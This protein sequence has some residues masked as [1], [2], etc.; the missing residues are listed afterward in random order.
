M[1]ARYEDY[2]YES[3]LATC[4]HAYLMPLIR[5]ML[6]GCGGPILDIGCGNGAIARA[7]LADGFDVHGIDASATGVEIASAAAPGR[8]FV[9][10][11]DARDLPPQL[12]GTAFAAVMST[13]VIEHLYAP[14]ALLALA[15]RV[16][17]PGGDLVLSTPYHGYL[18]NLA[19]AASGRLDRHFTVLWDGGHIKF[20]S[21]ATLGRMLREEGFEVTRFAG[22]GR[23]PL[24]WKS[25][26]L[27][28]RVVP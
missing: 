17:A 7:L 22:A 5:E 11:L 9:A 24:F 25:M 19:L 16:L 12:A 3:G 8:F 2:A 28:A 21:R 15:R 14:R 4:A 26:V 23:V 18:K 6:A 10:D 1:T 27:K 20:F 13:E